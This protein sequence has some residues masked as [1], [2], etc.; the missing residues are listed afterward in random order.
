[1]SHE[2]KC[3]Y[4]GYIGKDTEFFENVCPACCR[5]QETGKLAEG[6]IP[7]VFHMEEDDDRTKTV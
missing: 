3:P 6:A 4:C 2:H 7:T 1:M 5:D